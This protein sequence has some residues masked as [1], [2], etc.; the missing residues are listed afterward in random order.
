VIVVIRA[1]SL[2][3][4]I[5]ELAISELACSELASEPKNRPQGSSVFK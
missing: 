2:E 4:A 1:T 3:L 5:S